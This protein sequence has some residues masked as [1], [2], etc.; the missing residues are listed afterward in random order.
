MLQ[1]PETAYTYAT[2]S[3]AA[4]AASSLSSSGVRVAAITK[5]AVG[6]T[7]GFVKQ[8]YATCGIR[9]PSC[10]IDFRGFKTARQTHAPF[11]APIAAEGETAEHKCLPVRPHSTSPLGTS[12]LL[13]WSHHEPLHSDPIRLRPALVSAQSEPFCFVCFSFP[14]FLHAWPR[15][16]RTCRVRK[17]LLGF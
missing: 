17:V 8:G 3:I 6:L 1:P 2:Y 4:S 7:S 16:L 5:F 11:G 14:H 12:H 13:S 10:A 9:S 15:C